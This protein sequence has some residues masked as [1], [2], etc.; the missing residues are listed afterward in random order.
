M[1]SLTLK[2]R[3]SEKAYAQSQTDNVYI[4]VVPGT[5]N[6]HTIADAVTAQFD[7]TVTNVRTVIQKGKAVQSRHKRS[8]AVTVHRADMKKAYVT[9]KAGDSI[10]IFDVPEEQPVEKKAA[11]KTAKETK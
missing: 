9:L 11:K 4:F 8:R 6:K 10:A 5:A 1:K 2:P 3:M 7:V